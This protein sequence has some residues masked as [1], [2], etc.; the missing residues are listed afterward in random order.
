MGKVKKFKGVIGKNRKK[1]NKKIVLI[2][3]I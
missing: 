2:K 1:L 3:N